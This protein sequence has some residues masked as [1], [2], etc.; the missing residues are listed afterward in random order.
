MYDPDKQAALEAQQLERERV[1][2]HERTDSVNRR[3]EQLDELL[4]ALHDRLEP[5]LTPAR[6]R[7]SVAVA[8]DR[9]DGGS[10]LADYLDATGRRLESSID[11][12]R[13]LLERIEL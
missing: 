12:A 13:E 8:P 6:V 4:R 2:L 3:L 1:P 7:P 11:G 9:S 5:V 10:W